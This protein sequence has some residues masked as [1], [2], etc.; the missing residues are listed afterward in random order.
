M[1]TLVDLGRKIRK[2]KSVF[3]GDTSESVVVFAP[4]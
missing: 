2:S 1:A 3:T 4:W